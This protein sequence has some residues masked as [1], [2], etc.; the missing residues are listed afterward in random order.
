MPL[1]DLVCIG[2]LLEVDKGKGAGIGL[3]K[4]AGKRSGVGLGK[5]LDNEE[6]LG[7]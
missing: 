4:G 7:K 1:L 6:E 3:G 5:E 2:C